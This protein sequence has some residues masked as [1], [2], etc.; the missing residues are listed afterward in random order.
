MRLSQRQQKI[1]SIFLK[2]ETRQSSEIHAE[3]VK[4][5]EKVSLVTVK[6]ALSKLAEARILTAAGSGRSASYNISAAG[7]ILADID[8]HEYCSMEPDKR[9]GLK[10]YNFDL[11]S[12]WPPDFFTDD[13]LIVLDNASAE[14]KIRI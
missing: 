11:L 3:M 9:Y 14:Y 13:E 12:A 8:A 7:R 5:G 4:S 2:Q 6:R 1:I 10:R